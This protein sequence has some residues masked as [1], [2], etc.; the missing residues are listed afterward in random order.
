MARAVDR[1]AGDRRRALGRLLRPRRGAG[2]PHPR[3]RADH[4]GDRGRQPPPRRLRGRRVGGTADRAQLRPA[5]G[6]ARDRR[7][8]DDRPAEALRLGGA[9]VLRGRKPRRRRPGATPLPLGRLP[10]VLDGGRGPAARAGA[11]EPRLA[12]AARPRPAPRRGHRRLGAGPRGPRG[13][14]ADDGA[15]GPLAAGPAPGR[16]AR[17]AARGFAPGPDRLRPDGAG[18]GGGDREARSGERL[19]GARRAHLAA[20]LRRPRP[21]AGD[22]RLRADRPRQTRRAGARPGPP[23]RRDADLQA[24]APVARRPARDVAA[25]RRPGLR[26]ER[27]DPDRRRDRPRR[28]GRPGGRARRIA[29]RS[30]G[31]ARLGRPLARRGNGRRGRGRGRARGHRTAE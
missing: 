12:R 13:Q 28:G 24:A 7:R 22:R 3:R 30:A 25:R 2:D 20:S 17:R 11:P 21:L 8:P 19:P 29:R 1:C 15:P 26:L 6:A 23:L 18:S 10:R 16:R 31:R 4:L 9:L 27:A 5:A 14:A